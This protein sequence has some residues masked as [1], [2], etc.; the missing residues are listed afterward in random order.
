MI[1]TGS[2]IKK[3]RLEAGFTQRQLAE[4]ARVSQAHV[5]KIEKGRVDP[6][7]S[8]VNR[9][10]QVLTE[11]EGKKCGDIMTKDVIFA[12][13]R[14][15]ILKA[16]EVMMRH[17]ISQ[18]PVIKNE[19]VV[20][21]ITEDGIIKNLSS[22]IAEERVEKVMQAPLPIVPEDMRVSMIKPLLEDH[23]GVLVTRKGNI[24]GIITKSDLLK[25]ISKT[26]Q[27][28]QFTPIKHSQKEKV[29]PP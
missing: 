27:R 29:V 13:P 4:L 21:T 2:I 8:T 25:T 9:I 24:V 22:T 3:L 23:P 15:K 19:R 7:L 10:L 14:D 5:A 6:R 28:P 16:S 17:A 1:V 11:G 18:L 12:R 20:S 26:L